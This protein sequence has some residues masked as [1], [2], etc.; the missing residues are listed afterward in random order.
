MTFVL[1]MN[2]CYNII[3]I[4]VNYKNIL[5][6]YQGGIINEIFTSNYW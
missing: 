5:R 4:D 6:Y 1:N 3:M 2:A